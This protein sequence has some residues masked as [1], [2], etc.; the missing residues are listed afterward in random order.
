[1]IAASGYPAWHRPRRGQGHALR[2]A[3]GQPC[4]RLR[5]AH[6]HRRRTR[7]E[8]TEH[9]NKIHQLEVSTLSGDGHIGDAAEGSRRAD[10]AVTASV[11]RTE[12]PFQALFITGVSLGGVLLL[13]G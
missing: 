10:G 3:Y 7:P 4:P 8:E 13:G 2:V 9:Q 12:D 1:M 11:G 6:S 5:A